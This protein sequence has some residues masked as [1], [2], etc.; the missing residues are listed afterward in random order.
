MTFMNTY[1]LFSQNGGVSFRFG[2]AD[3]IA[4]SSTSIYSYKPLVT[5]ATGIG[6]QFGNGGGY[7]SKVGAG[8]GVY[9]SGT[10]K[11][12]FDALEHTSLVP[13]VLPADAVEPMQA[14]TKQQLDALLARIEALEAKV[15]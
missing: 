12:K 2:G 13:I 3:L 14:V 7:M 11:F 6:I 9:V 8:I 15:K 4:F 10:Q 5:P 1:S